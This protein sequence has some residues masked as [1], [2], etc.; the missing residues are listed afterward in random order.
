MGRQ[1]R[2]RDLTGPKFSEP[3]RVPLSHACPTPSWDTQLER[4]QHLQAYLNS[5]AKENAKNFCLV[6]HGCPKVSQTRRGTRNPFDCASWSREFV[7]FE[8]VFEKEISAAGTVFVRQNR[9]P[10]PVLRFINRDDKQTSRTHE[11]QPPQM[12]VLASVPPR[13]KPARLEGHIIQRET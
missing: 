4:L 1:E 9:R 7:H 10:S 3:N 11:T 5:I 12:R 6:S 13:Q 8:K 2:S